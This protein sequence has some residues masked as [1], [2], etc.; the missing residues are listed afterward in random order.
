MTSDTSPYPRHGLEN[1]TRVSMGFVEF[2]TKLKAAEVALCHPD[3]EYHWRKKDTL[4]WNDRFE[5][6]LQRRRDFAEQKYVLDRLDNPSGNRGA[7]TPA[8]VN[9]H[10]GDASL[11]S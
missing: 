6:A 10:G 9:A 11:C 2:G 1:P 3:C 4:L 8:R 7:D 5:R